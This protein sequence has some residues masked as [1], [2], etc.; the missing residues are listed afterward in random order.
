LPWLNSENDISILLAEFQG[1]STPSSI[2]VRN[3]WLTII[4]GPAIGFGVSAPMSYGEPPSGA[5][6]FPTELNTASTSF[7][8]QERWNSTAST[9]GDTPEILVLQQNAAPTSG[10]KSRIRSSSQRY[11]TMTVTLHFN[12]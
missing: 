3:S 5:F 6:S 1:I 8:D 7:T 10:D 11:L 2:K 4:A 12:N 9:V